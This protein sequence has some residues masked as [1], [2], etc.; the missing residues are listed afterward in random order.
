[1]PLKDGLISHLELSCRLFTGWRQCCEFPTVLWF[2]W[3]VD[4]KGILP[5]KTRC[6]Y[7]QTFCFGDP[8]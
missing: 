4:R 3:L 7:P 2:C 1:M 8:V 6:S 5:V